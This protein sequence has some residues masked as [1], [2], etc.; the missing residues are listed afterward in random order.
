MNK[1]IFIAMLAVTPLCAQEEDY[2]FK[3]D[4]ADKSIFESDPVFQSEYDG[5]AFKRGDNNNGNGWGKGGNGNGNNGNGNGNSG[6]APINFAIHFFT[7]FIVG[8]GIYELSKRRKR[9]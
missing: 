2:G 7:G 6:D 3:A 8:Y 4:E 1:L 5:D 9:I